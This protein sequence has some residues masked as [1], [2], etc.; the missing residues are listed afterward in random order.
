MLQTA[1]FSTF[2][3]FFQYYWLTDWREYSL[4]SHDFFS[5]I[6]KGKERKG[7]DSGNQGDRNQLF[8]RNKKLGLFQFSC[9]S[10][11]TQLCTK[12]HADSLIRPLSMSS[13]ENTPL[14]AAPV[15]TENDAAIA[16][17]D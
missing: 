6:K 11:V 1:G 8:S 14:V 7:G 4:D 2:S 9:L 5:A 3:Y 13:N 12:R 10:L 16:H 17:G 15:S